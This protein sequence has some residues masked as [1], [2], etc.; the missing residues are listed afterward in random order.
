MTASLDATLGGSASNSYVTLAEADA[1][2]E[3]VS[4][5]VTWLAVADNARNIALIESCKWLETLRFQ[6]DRCTP[7]TDSSTLTQELKWPRKNT[8]NDSVE[9]V[10][11][12]IP[13]GIKAAQIE[14]AFQL[15]QETDA[16]VPTPGGGGDTPPGLYVRK[17][18][19]GSLSQEFAEY[20]K[21]GGSCTDCG[22]PDVIQ[23]FPWL[24]GFLEGWIGQIGT[25]RVLTRVRS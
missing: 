22:D 14:L 19:L 15:S 23:K 18:Q 3:N 5:G 25:S 12:L 13:P 9:A 24:K 21:G 8:T 20:S 6:G 10:C 17:Q 16:I 11:T 2:A 4:W 7:S 1:Y